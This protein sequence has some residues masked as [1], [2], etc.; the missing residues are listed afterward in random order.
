MGTDKSD[1][2][3]QRPITLTAITI[4][5]LL[6]ISKNRAPHLTFLNILDPLVRILI[7]KNIVLGT[8]SRKESWFKWASV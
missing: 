6:C 8:T 2:N 1:H 3:K 4:S 5:G 7:S